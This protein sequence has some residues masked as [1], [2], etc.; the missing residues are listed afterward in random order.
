MKLRHEFRVIQTYPS[1]KNIAPYFAICVNDAAKYLGRAATVHAIYRGD[2]ARS[3]LNKHGHHSQFQI[4]HATPAQRIEWQ[5]L[6]QPNRPGTSSHEQKSDA[7]IYRH[8]PVGHDLPWWGVGIDIDEIDVTAV[9]RA[10][11]GHGWQLEQPYHSGNEI[12]HLNF[13]VR[14]KPHNIKDVA[15]IIRLRL[16]L[17]RS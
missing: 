13:R 2:D 14:P 5:I 6:G 16:T 17:P 3:I 1:P 15:R 8:I 11:R 9:I 4:Y 12:H 7:V 10:A